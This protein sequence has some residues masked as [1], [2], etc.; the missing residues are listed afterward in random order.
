MADIGTPATGCDITPALRSGFQTLQ[1]KTPKFRRKVE[2][3]RIRGR[4]GR[5]G[6]CNGKGPETEAE[7]E[8]KAGPAE[9]EARA[10]PAEQ[11]GQGGAGK[12]RSLF[13]ANK[14]RS[15][16]DAS[17]A[18]SLVETNRVKGLGGVKMAS[19]PTTGSKVGSENSRT[20][21]GS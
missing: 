9:Q 21:A 17:R 5:P 11:G 18:R 4:D 1:Q 13:E 15:L 16:S 20:G 2:R 6:P 12:V 7:Q 3:R 19:G 14:A 10:G 8:A